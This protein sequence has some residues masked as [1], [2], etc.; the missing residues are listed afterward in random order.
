MRIV[1]II[2]C[3][4][5]CPSAIIGQNLKDCFM[6][7]RWRYKYSFDADT[8]SF[9]RKYKIN[10]ERYKAVPVPEEVFNY[11]DIF[12]MNIDSIG[13]IESRYKLY[14]YA[15]WGLLKT[16]PYHTKKYAYPTFFLSGINIEYVAARRSKTYEAWHAIV[17]RFYEKY[18]ILYCDTEFL[19]L[20]ISHIQLNEGKSRGRYIH[21]YVREDKLGTASEFIRNDA[22]FIIPFIEAYIQKHRF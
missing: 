8:S 12:F 15:K 17:D 1:I 14:R 19:V 3:I 20:Y 4:G 22:Y 9:N 6:N 21:V 11:Y 10:P 18:E 7:Q 2:L 5:I 16:A 13:Y